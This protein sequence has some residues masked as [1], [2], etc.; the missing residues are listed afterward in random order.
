MISKYILSAIFI[1]LFASCIGKLQSAEPLI[2]KPIKELTSPI[3]PIDL[4]FY[5]NLIKDI[6]LSPDGNWIAFIKNDNGVENIFLVSSKKGL[7]ESFAVTHSNEPIK[8]FEWTINSKQIIFSKDQGGNENTQIYM[9]NIG[10][11]LDKNQKIKITSLTNK[12][13]IRYDFIKQI[14]NSPDQILVMSNQDN[15]EQMDIFSLDMQSRKLKKMVNNRYGFGNLAFNEAGEAKIA[16]GMNQN[17]TQ[18]LYV[19]KNQEWLPVFTSSRGE[20]IEILSLNGSNNLAYISA[21]IQGRD[22][23]EL[24]AFNLTNHTFTS[25]HKDPKNQADIHD[26]DF[27]NKGKPV[28]VSYYGGRLR[29]YPID[30]V[31]SKHWHIINQYFTSDVEIDIN[32]MDEKTKIWQLT[33]ASDIATDVS[34]SYNASTGKIQA[35]LPQTPVIKPEYIPTRKSIT[36]QARDGLSIQAYLTIPK[37]KFKNLPTIILPHGGPWDRDYWSLS[38]NPLPALFAN[39]GYAV[40]QPNY[41]ASTGFGK[42]FLN[43][44]NLQWGTGSM[45]H[46]L[47]DGVN[48]LIQQG[49]ADKNRVGIMGGSYGGYA[50]LSGITFTPD[51]YKAAISYVGPSSLLTL[52]EAFPPHFRPYLGQFFSAIGDPLIESDRID[53]QSRSPINF[54]EQIKTP[55]LLIQGA[56]DPRVTQKESDNIAKA[57]SHKDLAVEYILAKDEGHGFMKRENKLAAYIAM[58]RF[59]AKHLGGKFDTAPPKKLSNHLNTLKVE[60]NKL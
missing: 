53:M 10:N 9:A 5:E 27:N 35:L 39:R 59:F 48:Y 45:Q 23:K 55:L 60:I 18:T 54:I 24:L 56:N 34:Y 4:F 46:D 11:K 8:T 44:G 32:T 12:P 57:M 2:N 14:K 33:V 31:F 52:I 51:L 49:I 15:A 37:N 17:N 29:T 26:V 22:K 58:E 42:K 7:D 21:D 3:I 41:R 38:S 28:S 36:Y 25:L 30:K 40:L 20:N 13:K 43:L 50:A 47:T 1:G 19:K 6:K 16:Q